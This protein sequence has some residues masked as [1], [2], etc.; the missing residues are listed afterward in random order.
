MEFEKGLLELNGERVIERIFKIVSSIFNEILLSTNDS[1]SYSS[2]GVPTVG[3]YFLNCGPLGGIHVGLSKSTTEKNF[4][5]SGDMPF[6]SEEAIRYI[7]GYKTEA[8]IL[9]PKAEGRIQYLCGIYSKNIL[10]GLEKNLSKE[11]LTSDSLKKPS[12]GV[13]HLIGTFDVEIVNVERKEFYYKDLFFNMNS[14]E[15]YEYVKEK[16]SQVII[17]SKIMS[18]SKIM[19]MNKSYEH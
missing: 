7:A 13:K 9:L 2:L 6:I 17:Q 18:K 8:E 15:D 19:S 16:L 12:L 14:P 3:D 10:P 5:I 11:Q 4:I 1:G